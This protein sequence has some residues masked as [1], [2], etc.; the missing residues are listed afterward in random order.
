MP[1]RLSHIRLPS[2][3][4]YNDASRLQEALVRRFLDSKASNQDDSIQPTI[5][6]MQMKPVYTTGRRERGLL[7]QAERY[8]LEDNG[9]ADVIES[10]RG[11]QTTFHGPGQLV[12]YPILDISKN[13]FNIK[14]RCYVDLLEES[15]I[16]TLSSF[17]LSAIRTEHTGVWMNHDKKIAAVGV[18]L[19]R[20]ITSHGIALNVNT[21]LAFFDKI[22]ACGLADKRTTSMTSEGSQA[23]I[24]EVTTRF[25]DTLAER[26][27]CL[28]VCES[29]EMGILD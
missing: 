17:G 11:G 19:R 14:A 3:I 7:S 22:I 21:D 28:E 10:L 13:S 6:T 15:I 8:K 26:L 5:M 27:G 18:H 29:S 9:R 1:P 2:P 4:N 23:T 12:A 24:E 20:N 25:V 16:A